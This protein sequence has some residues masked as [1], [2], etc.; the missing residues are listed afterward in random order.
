MKQF[1]IR[2][3]HCLYLAFSFFPLLTPLPLPP[4]THG[5]YHFPLRT[6]SL[7]AGASPPTCSH[8]HPQPGARGL[9][10]PVDGLWL[11]LR[12]K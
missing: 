2:L 4:L 5:C 8:V 3:Y 7:K 11:L 1:E 10:H 9:A 6:R 12:A